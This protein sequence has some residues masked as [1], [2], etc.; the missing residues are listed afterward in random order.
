MTPGWRTFA[1]A[2]LRQHGTVK[3]RDVLRDLQAH[4]WYVQGQRGSHRVL[5]HHEHPGRRVVL[6]GGCR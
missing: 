5:R 1:V 3:V 4:C 2:T 6:A